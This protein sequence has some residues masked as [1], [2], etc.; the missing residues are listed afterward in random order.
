M[1]QERASSQNDS[2]DRLTCE[3]LSALTVQN[4]ETLPISAMGYNKESRPGVNLETTKKA[5]S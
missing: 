5:D 4:K 2:C 1:L 3:F